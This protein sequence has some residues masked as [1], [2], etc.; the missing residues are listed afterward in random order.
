MPANSARATAASMGACSTAGDAFEGSPC[1]VHC[2]LPSCGRDCEGTLVWLDCCSFAFIMLACVQPYKRH[3][4]VFDERPHSLWPPRLE[5]CW[6]NVSPFI[7]Y[8]FILPAR[9]IAVRARNRFQQSVSGTR[10]CFLNNDSR[11]HQPP[12]RNVSSLRRH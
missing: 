2:K 6:F 3:V 9:A 11:K 10:C 8:V 7:Y 5:V 1:V 12:F 4:V